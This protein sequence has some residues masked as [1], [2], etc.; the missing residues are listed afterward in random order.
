MCQSY[1]AALGWL[2]A[3]ASV[4]A[5]GAQRHADALLHDL[6]CSACAPYM[7]CR[8]K[9]PTSGWTQLA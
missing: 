7:T 1:A 8:S 2:T 9:E 5:E 3:E 4:Q 6:F